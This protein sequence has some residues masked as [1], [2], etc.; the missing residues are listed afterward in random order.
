LSGICS[1]Q[2]GVFWL[3]HAI[4]AS[5]H[6]DMMIARNPERDCNNIQASPAA[7]PINLTAFDRLDDLSAIDLRR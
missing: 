6:T 3:P 5:A 1:K 2:L 4:R 7:E